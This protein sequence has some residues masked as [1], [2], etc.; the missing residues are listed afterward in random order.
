MPRV[1]GVM[2]AA[3][4]LVGANVHYSQPLIPL[5]AATFA[6]STASAGIIPAV[7]QVGFALSIL[8][9]LPLA[10]LID[11]RRIIVVT[12]VIAC[13]ALAV[14]ATS[15]SFM[16]VTVA[17]FF[18]GVG[19]V[20]PQV[21]SP[22]AAAIAPASRVGQASGL[23]L[24]GILLGVL[25]SKVVAGFVAATVSW[26]WLF[27]GASIAMVLIAIVLAVVLPRPPV[28]SER[29]DVKSL[30]LGPF[31]LVRTYARLRMHAALGALAS[32]AFMAFWATYAVHL[33]EEFGYGPLVAGLFGVAGM[34]G[35]LLAPVAGRMV[36]RGRTVVTITWAACAIVIA[37][38]IMWLGGSTTGILVAGVVLLDA[39][40][41]V[42]HSLNQARLFRINAS[43]RSRLNSVYMFSYFAGGSLGAIV[44]AAAYAAFGWAGVCA[45]GIASAVAIGVVVARSRDQLSGPVGV[46]STT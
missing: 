30:L 10:D 32:F 18:V 5:M 46:V 21:L 20:A 29:P 13:A 36:D 14:T 44:G 40:V 26:R 1:V 38:G 39:G 41:G 33:T 42:A 19:S 7:T 45:V 27:I 16:A 25:L 17:A 9:I 6:V 11:R 35:S 22:F 4:G 28:S 3:A 37:F 24:S 43:Q 31:S 2:A 23:V 12:I 15:T 8:V 34:A